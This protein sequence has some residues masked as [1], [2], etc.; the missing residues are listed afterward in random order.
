MISK[1]LL[2]FVVALFLL[3]GVESRAQGV[4]QQAV[5]FS[6]SPHAVGSGARAMGWGNAFIAVADDATAASWNPGGLT[7]LIKP[8][9]SVAF[10]YHSR[11]ED[12]EFSG[13]NAGSDSRSF[14]RLNLNYASVAYPF[15]AGGRNMVVSLNYQRLYEFD[16]D[17][18]YMAS[19]MLAGN[20]SFTES[21]ELRQW[22]ALTTVTPAFCIQVIPRLSVGAAVNFWGMEDANNGW[23]QEWELETTTKN[24][25]GE[26][27]SREWSDTWE[28]YQLSGI[29]YVI[30][31]HYK[32]DSWTF[33]AVYK[34]SWEA[35]VDYE[36]EYEQAA[37]FPKN[38]L[39]NY[40]NTFT[41]DDDQTLV[42]PES[43]G[44]GAAYRYSDRLTFALDVYTTRWSQYELETDSGDINLLAVNDPEADVSNDAYKVHAG[45]EYLWILPK[46]V[47]A[48]RTGIFYEPEPFQDE[49][50]ESYGAALG[51]GLVYENYVLDVAF[52]YRAA[53]DMEGEQIRGVASELDSRD[54]LALVSLVYHI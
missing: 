19:G 13:L 1:K 48:L 20:S 8:E 46:Y 33:A 38:A 2:V 49:I 44:V 10:S 4:V 47:V 7:Q 6:S 14:S 27:I 12:L 21:R 32:L 15:N 42:W 45:M 40:H 36:R 28:K 29:N 23:E 41:M 3:A 52:Q 16:R 54:I 24:A 30:G 5:P 34:S 43:W 25:A 35:D 39:A 9:A 22:G 11:Y 31:V 26:V 50:N 51:G 17:L 18:S 53:D 37:V